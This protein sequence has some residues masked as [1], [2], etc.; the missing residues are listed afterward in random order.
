L[1][2]IDIADL[3]MAKYYE[4]IETDYFSQLEAFDFLGEH[5]TIEEFA[6]IWLEEQGIF[7]SYGR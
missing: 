4:D 7:Y 6:C 5:F 3:Y 1:E 2:V